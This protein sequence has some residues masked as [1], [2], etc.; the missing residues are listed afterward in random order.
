MPSKAG[1]GRGSSRAGETKRKQTAPIVVRPSIDAVIAFLSKQI[2]DGDGDLQKLIRSTPAWR[3]ADDLLQS[4]PG[5]GPVLSIGL[6]ALAPELGRLSRK[7]IAALIGVTPLNNDSGSRVGK[8]STWGGRAPVRAVL[9][10][11]AIAA[12][13]FNSTIAIFYDRLIDH[14]KPPKVA[15]VACMRKLLVMLNAMVRDRRAWSP[16]L[17][18]GE[19]CP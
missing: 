11:A 7:Q 6:T 15:L 5:V 12:K 13:R 14:G 2:D 1:E 19:K 17:P 16:Q 9:Y 10:M 8:R 4:V 18:P 3:D